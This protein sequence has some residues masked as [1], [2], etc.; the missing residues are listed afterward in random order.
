MTPTDLI[1][2]RDRLKYILDSGFDREIIG[3]TC[4]DFANE[5]VWA[6]SQCIERQEDVDFIN[7]ALGILP[8]DEND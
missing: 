8:L 5:I 6:L 3:S 2:A 1:K 4:E 7:N